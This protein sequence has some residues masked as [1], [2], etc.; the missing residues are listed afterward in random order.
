[1]WIEQV[2]RLLVSL[3]ERFHATA[4]LGVAAAGALQIG[5]TL[6]GRRLFQRS[7]EDRFFT[8]G[9]LSLEAVELE[10]AHGATLWTSTQGRESELLARTGILFDNIPKAGTAR[11]LDVR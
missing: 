6:G 8:H 3:Q 1:M 11:A 7:D 5:C 10:P 9:R 4:E 2:S